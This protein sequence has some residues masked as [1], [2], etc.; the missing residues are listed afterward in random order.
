M[1]NN[2]EDY[3]LVIPNNIP[4]NICVDVISR[5]DNVGWERHRYY[6]NGERTKESKNGEQE[7][8]VSADETVGSIL[9]QYISNSFNSYFEN[10]P[11]LLSRMTAFSPPRFNKYTTNT[12]MD[13]HVDHIRS[14]FMDGDDDRPRGIPVLSSLSILNDDYSGGEFIMFDDTVIKTDIGTTIVFPSNFLYPHKVNPITD[15][16][17]YSCVSW[18]V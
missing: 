13:K 3:V 7:F 10:F 16:V 12:L 15:G 1:K 11:E 18:G 5:L 8:F 6:D 4:T 17:R 2:I 9:N 14:I